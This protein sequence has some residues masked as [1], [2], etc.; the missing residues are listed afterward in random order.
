M[1]AGGKKEALVAYLSHDAV[2]LASLG[3]L[4][5]LS[6]PLGFLIVWKVTRPPFRVSSFRWLYLTWACVLAATLVW[7]VNRTVRFSVNQAGADNFVRLAFLSLSLLLILAIGSSYRFAF[8]SESATGVLAIFTLFSLWGLASTSWSV[9]PA[10]SLY[11][12]LE[13]FTQL[14]LLA[15]TASLINLTIRDPRRR[16]FALKRVFDFTWLLVFLLIASVY[17]GVVVLP[18]YGIIHGIRNTSGILGFSIQGA[19]PAIAANAVGQLGAILGLVSFVRLLL[20]SGSRILYGVLLAISLVTMVLTQSRSPI[21][22]FAVAVVAVLLASRRFKLLALSGVLG[23]A[24]LLTQY[25]QLVYEFMRRGQSENSLMTLTGRIS[26]WKASLAAVRER[27]LGGYGAY[28]GGRYVL[29]SSL[30]DT[31]TATVHSLWVEVL[32]DTGVVG[33]IL[34]LIGIVATWLWLLRLRPYAMKTPLNRL[35]WFECLGV[36]TIQCVRSIFAVDLVWDW[37]VL[38]FGIILVFISVVRRQISEIRYRSVAPAQPP[39][40]V[41][42]PR[43]IVRD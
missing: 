9:F 32:L 21:L 1:A 39:L 30:G 13:Y 22:A 11:K 34:I 3:M 25:G 12:S 35:L 29:S 14:M 23:V 18:Q 4:V 42:Q 7:N 33:V 41:R 40:A 20:K 43:P 28:D 26:Y 6:V 31:S 15:L 37:N 17:M 36:L 8:F 2:A 5:L 10:G 27:L 38:F 19:L 16:S 24:V